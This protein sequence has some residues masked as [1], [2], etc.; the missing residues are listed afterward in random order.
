MPDGGPQMQVYS[1]KILKQIYDIFWLF[2]RYWLM[3]SSSR[4]YVN[5]YEEKFEPSFILDF[6][7]QKV[8]VLE[9]IAYRFCLKYIVPIY[10][11]DVGVSGY[12]FIVSAEINCSWTWSSFDQSL[13]TDPSSACPHLSWKRTDQHS[14][15]KFAGNY[16]QNIQG[17][18]LRHN[19]GR[20]DWTSFVSA[21]GR[22]CSTVSPGSCV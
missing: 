14:V 12:I 11:A 8:V 9:S 10:S 5:K 6:N 19:F 15:C 13:Q 4:I 2:L 3:H 16:S 20:L 7:I 18:R 1:N 21:I 22:K 17:R